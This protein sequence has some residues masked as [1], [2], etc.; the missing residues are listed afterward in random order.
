MILNLKNV[1]VVILCGGKGERLSAVVSDRPKALAHVRGTPLIDLLIKKLYSAGLRRFIL[2]TGYLK[3][4]LRNHIDKIVIANTYPGSSFVFSEEDEPLGTGGALKNAEKLI[5]SE[6]FIL[7]NGDTLWTIDFDNLYKHHYSKNALFTF[8]LIDDVNLTDYGR[9]ILTE[10]GATSGFLEKSDTTRNSFI[11]AGVYLVNKKIFKHM[12]KQKSFSL[13]YDVLP[14]LAADK[15]CSGFISS[16][17]F[18]DIGTP[19]RYRKAQE[20]NFS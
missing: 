20:G 10:D 14:S 18:L 9:V 12:P 19:E 1:D 15:L 17:S 4:Q 11:S 2:C 13:E 6:N 3:N 8:T 7:T 5:Q 16:S